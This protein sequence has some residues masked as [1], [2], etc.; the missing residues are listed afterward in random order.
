MA[1]I[2][3]GSSERLHQRHRLLL[4]DAAQGF[5]WDGFNPP[6]GW[7]NTLAY[8]CCQLR[9]SYRSTLHCHSDAQV[10]RSRAAAVAAILKFLPLMIGW[11][12]L[13]VPSPGSTG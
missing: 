10:R 5:A 6:L 13:S 9:W 8:P 4:G 7:D 3:G 11:F 2:A 1:A 12:S